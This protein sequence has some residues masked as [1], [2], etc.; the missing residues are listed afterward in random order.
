MTATDE[1]SSPEDSFIIYET[2]FLIYISDSIERLLTISNLFGRKPEPKFNC[3][4]RAI[5]EFPPDGL[6]KTQR[7]M[8]MIIFH[9]IISCYCFWL[10]ATVCD[11]YFVPSIEDMCR[12][13]F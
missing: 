13:N 12:S 9:L 6:T 5:Y 11:E 1:I 8:G 2:P 3:T 4:P 10:L 7:Q